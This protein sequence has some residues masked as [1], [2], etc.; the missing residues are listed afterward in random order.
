MN[1]PSNKVILK[2]GSVPIV[3][4]TALLIVSLTVLITSKANVELG[5]LIFMYICIVLLICVGAFLRYMSYQYTIDEEHLLISRGIIHKHNIT[6]PY[7]NIQDVENERDILDLVFGTST[8][9]VETAGAGVVSAN[10]EIPGIDIN[11]KVSERIINYKNKLIH[12]KSRNNEGPR[13]G[14]EIKEIEKAIILLSDE[15]YNL[16]I[17]FNVL[18]EKIEEMGKR[19]PTIEEIEIVTKKHS[20]DLKDIKSDTGSIN[21]E[22][23]EKYMKPSKSKAPKKKKGNLKKPTKKGNKRI[24]K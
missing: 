21:R 15:I 17:N 18:S 19:Q 24:Q 5:L 9:K 20:V 6:V 10:V 23:R 12:I 13:E 3:I 22:K 7:V 4:V 1:K 8:I 2:W 16:R 14:G 11:S